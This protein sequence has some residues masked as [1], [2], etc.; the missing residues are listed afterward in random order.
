MGLTRLALGLTPRQGG[1]GFQLDA[2]QGIS[3][4]IGLRI[5]LGLQ[6]GDL[7]NQARS[8]I[9]REPGITLTKLC[10]RA[11]GRK[12]GLARNGSTATQLHQRTRTQ[13]AQEQIAIA[14]E[15]RPRAIAVVHR[16]GRI[17]IRPFR[18]LQ[19]TRHTIGQRHRM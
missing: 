11:V 5:L 7:R 19:R 9:H 3:L 16:I 8:Q 10:L 12:L 18:I 17:Q 6:R 2:A 4:G 1:A 14:H 15:Q 13:V